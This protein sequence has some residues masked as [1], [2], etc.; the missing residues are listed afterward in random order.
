MSCK[1]GVIFCWFWSLRYNT[2][3]TV[4][5]V[6]CIDKIQH[7]L[8]STTIPISTHPPFFFRAPLCRSGWRDMWALVTVKRPSYASSRTPISESLSKSPSL[9]E[10]GEAV[11]INVALPLVNQSMAEC[12]L[13]PK[14]IMDSR[15]TII[16]TT[17]EISTEPTYQDHVKIIHWL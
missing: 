11:T 16:V 9:S 12:D 5:V 17:L 4:H 3:P 7:S 2:S 6:L 1:G 15:I 10:W 14:V 8:C 13:W